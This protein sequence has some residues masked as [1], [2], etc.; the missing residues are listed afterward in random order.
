MQGKVAA[1]RAQDNRAARGRYL[2]TD[3]AG[4]S[5]QAVADPDPLPASDC[6]GIGLGSETERTRRGIALGACLARRQGPLEG[7]EFAG[8]KGDISP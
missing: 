8:P 2:S 5:P 6:D 3:M 4:R 1:E 7:V